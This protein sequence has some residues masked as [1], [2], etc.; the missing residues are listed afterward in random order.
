MIELLIIGTIRRVLSLHSWLFLLVHR[1]PCKHDNVGADRAALG[2]TRASECSRRVGK[3][4]VLTAVRAEPC[5][6]AG[7]R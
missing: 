4:V 2:A 7:K 1:V 6:E 5:C 3:K